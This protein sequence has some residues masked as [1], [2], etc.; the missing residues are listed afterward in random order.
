MIRQRIDIQNALNHYDH[1]RTGEY[2]RHHLSY[3][4]AER[5]IFTEGDDHESV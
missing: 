1:S 3:G 5:E 4:V 2:I